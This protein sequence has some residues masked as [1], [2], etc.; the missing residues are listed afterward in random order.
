MA[1]F[2]IYWSRGVLGREILYFVKSKPRESR[3]FFVRKAAIYEP[4]KIFL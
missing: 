2:L 3:Y 1:G 4:I